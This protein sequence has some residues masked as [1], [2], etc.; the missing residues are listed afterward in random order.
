MELG[1]LVI[2]TAS[3]ASGWGI[4]LHL[5]AKQ[6]CP[7]IAKSNSP[8]RPNESFTDIAS[9]QLTSANPARY[10]NGVHG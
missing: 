1:D 2:R 7:E 5:A 9:F 3:T 6:E 10:R 4:G 8:A